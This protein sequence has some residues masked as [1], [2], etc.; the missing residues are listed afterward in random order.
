MMRLVDRYIIITMD[1][2]NT[3]SEQIDRHVV[4]REANIAVYEHTLLLKKRFNKLIGKNR[5]VVC[6]CVCISPAVCMCMYMHEK[7]TNNVG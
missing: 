6:T 1:R 7:P 2:W 4:D 3:I 5:F